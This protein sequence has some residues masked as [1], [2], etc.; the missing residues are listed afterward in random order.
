MTKSWL[1]D[2]IPVST[3]SIGWSF[4]VYRKDR[5]IPRGGI[6]A[7]IHKSMPTKRLQHLETDDKEVV[8]LLYTPT[9]LQRPYS[10]IITAGLYFPPGKSAIEAKELIE[11]LT[12]CLDL[13]LMERPS[14]GIVITGDF[15]NLNPSQLCQRF[16]LR[17]VVRA[18]NTFD[19]LLTNMFK[20]YNRVQHLPP[21]GRYDHQCIL[22]ATLHQKAMSWECKNFRPCTQLGELE[23]CLWCKQRRWQDKII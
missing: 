22:F 13:V 14:A 2:C 5:P 18:P 12:E 3:I 4:S 16:C 1:S 17:K 11:Y 21:L 9:R 15:N 7:Y 8:W 20:L 19:Q 10:C 6:L 23:G